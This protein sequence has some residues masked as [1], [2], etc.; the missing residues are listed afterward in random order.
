MPATKRKLLI[1]GQILQTEARDRGM[2]RYS[3]YLLEVF[4]KQQTLYD[5]VEILLTTHLPLSQEE[6]NELIRLCKGAVLKKLDLVTTSNHTIETAFAHNQ[7]ALQTYINTQHPDSSVDFLIL[8]LFQEPT[9]TVFPNDCRKFLLFY[10]LIPYLYHKR[11]QAVMPFDNYLKRFKYIFEADQIFTISQTVADDLIIYLGIPKEQLTTINGAAIRAAGAKTKPAGILPKEFVLMP[12]SDDPRKNNLRAVLGFEEYRTINGDHECQLVITSKIS[13]EEQK[14]LQLASKQ[15]IFTGNLPEEQLD[16]L[17]EN[18]RAVLFTPEYEGLGLPILEAVEAGKN[19]VCSSINV[20]K[21]I[22]EDALCYC[23]HEDPA[24]IAQA[25]QVAISSKPSQ[26]AYK[27]IQERYTWGI[28]A[29]RLQDSMEKQTTPHLINKPRIAIFT[30]VPDGLSAIGKV[31]AESHAT[32]S[33]HF[34]IDYYID[35][36]QQDA[37]VRPNFLK[38]IAQT[39]PAHAFGAKAYQQYDAVIYHIGNGDYHLW[40]IQN[41]LYLPGYAIP[42]D[43]NIS[44][45]YRV[46][47]E[48]SMMSKERVQLEQ[49]LDRQNDASSHGLTTLFDRQLGILT[50]SQY[51]ATVAKYLVAKSTPIKLVNLPSAVPVLSAQ[52]QEDTIII[53]MAGIIADI[54]GISVI[55]SLAKHPSFSSCLI[56]IFGFN[57]ASQETIDRL[58]SY[59]N[60]TVTTNLSDFEFQTTLSKMHIFVNYRLGYN[61]ETSLATIEAMRNSVA[62]LVKNVGWYSELPNDTV[63]K[64]NDDSEVIEKLK[65]LLADKKYLETIGKNARHFIKTNFDHSQYAKGIKTL[66]DNSPTTQNFNHK[67]AYKLRKGSIKTKREYIKYVEENS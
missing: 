65:I 48:T 28:T 21:E 54:K 51:A 4:L 3:A 25:L 57:Y 58:N 41:A 12:S 10:D 22:S 38:Y 32:M 50:H 35:Y 55:E 37:A 5:E 23:D 26:N 62:V 20:F 59:S 2:G 66:I 64:I 14:Q 49:S 36:G 63:V 15:L 18:C 53:G 34:Q 31:V 1:D 47:G 42:H 24:S 11:Y 27:N 39:Q 33:Q 16:W 13:Q 29:K 56:K 6:R 19:I 60:V 17:Y 8:S 40:S 30:P 46:L 61:G 43:T 7:T 9:V 44:E 67:L 52:K 45:A